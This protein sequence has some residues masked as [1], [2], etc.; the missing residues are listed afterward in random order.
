MFSSTSATK[1]TP[2]GIP[3]SERRRCHSFL[4]GG[5]RLSDG[6]KV[7]GGRHHQNTFEVQPKHVVL[8]NHG[9]QFHV[10]TVPDALPEHHSKTKV[11]RQEELE[12]IQHRLAETHNKDGHGNKL[13]SSDV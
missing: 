9:V 8:P 6:V 4:D 13:N 2:D 11:F 10:E 12:S 3:P 5:C 1:K 7:D